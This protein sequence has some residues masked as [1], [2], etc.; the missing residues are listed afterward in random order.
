[1]GFLRWSPFQFLLLFFQAS[2]ARTQ[3]ERGEA[4][5]REVRRRRLEAAQA[6]AARQRRSADLRS[7]ANALRQTHVLRQD[8]LTET[9]LERI[10]VAGTSSVELGDKAGKRHSMPVAQLVRHLGK[11][12]FTCDTVAQL[13]QELTGEQTD[14]WP[15]HWPK[16]HTPFIAFRCSC[17]NVSNQ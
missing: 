17:P 5:R 14:D 4:K 1:M 3:R 16:D 2:R 11:L 8:E 6:L 13:E 15:T 9:E 12:G 7:L 10:H